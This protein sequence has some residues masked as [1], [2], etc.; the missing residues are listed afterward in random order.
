MSNL[1]PVAVIT[2]ASAGIG[3]ELAR[4]FARD[5]HELVLV[6][7][8]EDRLRALGY[9]ASVTG[10]FD[11]QTESVVKLFQAQHSDDSGLPLKID[12]EIGFHTWTALFG[13]LPSVVQPVAHL[14]HSSTSIAEVFGL[15]RTWSLSSG[16]GGGPSRTAKRYCI[17]AQ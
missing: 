2:G 14:F 17:S 10:I 13:V 3:A 6:A 12:G 11:A 4:V 16:R 5:R 15:T 7:R 1:R 8:R 9:G